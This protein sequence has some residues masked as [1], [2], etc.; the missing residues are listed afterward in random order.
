M[1][2]NTTLPLLTFTSNLRA[3]RKLATHELGRI[4]PDQYRKAAKIEVV[5]VLDD[6][7]SLHNVGAVF[8]T[9]DAFRI[10]AIY[11]CG[12]TAQPPHREIRKTALGATETVHW[13]YGKSVVHCCAKL[14]EEGYSIIGIEQ[15]DESLS[16]ANFQPKDYNKIALIFG[17]EVSGI[18]DDL[19]EFLDLSVEVPQF[20]TKHSLNISVCVGVVVW[21]VYSKLHY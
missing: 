4:T 19:I 14:K 1:D 10:S 7:R 9:A 2:K 13:Q 18:S 5:I 16:L 12:I 15:M 21:D 17:N 6:I 11:L 20:G 3:V 8:R